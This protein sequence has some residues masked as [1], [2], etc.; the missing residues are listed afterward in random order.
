VKAPR[1]QIGWIMVVVAI[2][3]LNFGAIRAMMAPGWDRAGGWLTVGALPMANA[4]VVGLL[5]ARRRPRS[6]PFLLGF[7]VFGGTALALYVA[8]VIGFEQDVLIPYL[9]LFMNPLENALGGWNGPIIF[10]P[11]VYSVAVLVLTLPQVALALLGGFLSR[12]FKISITRR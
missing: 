4:L 5:I 8:L 3:A 11:I 6:R 9:N 10:V 7:A 12:R 2:A 1:F